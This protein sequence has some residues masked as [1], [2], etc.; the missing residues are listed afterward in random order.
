MYRLEAGGLDPILDC[1]VGEWRELAPGL[2]GQR[3]SRETY[4]WKQWS[5]GMEPDYIGVGIALYRVPGIL[6]GREVYVGFGEGGEM[7]T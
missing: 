7:A 4:A 6:R 1:P 3:V 5:E 2:M